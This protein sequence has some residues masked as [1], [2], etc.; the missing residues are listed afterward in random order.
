MRI[1]LAI[2][3]LAPSLALAQVYPPDKPLFD[4]FNQDAYRPSASIDETGR[5]YHGVPTEP[6]GPTSPITIPQPSINTLG[7]GKSGDQYDRP[8]ELR[9]G[10]GMWDSGDGF[11]RDY[12]G[13]RKALCFGH[14]C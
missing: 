8:I 9:P 1:L 12:D 2:L 7:S 4:P 10:S 13:D 3:I 6:T 14:G 5:L 11:R